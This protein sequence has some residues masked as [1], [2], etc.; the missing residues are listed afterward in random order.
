MNSI[1]NDNKRLSSE[2]LPVFFTGL[3]ETVKKETK[4]PL[5]CILC[6]SSLVNKAKNNGN[7]LEKTNSYNGC[8]N[9][10]KNFDNIKAALE[11]LS[12]ISSNPSTAVSSPE[13]KD[14]NANIT[15]NK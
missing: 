2:N 14:D 8:E 13:L 7:S 5:L 6:G 10:A 11:L 4:V 9:C 1:K 15:R 3:T 12:K